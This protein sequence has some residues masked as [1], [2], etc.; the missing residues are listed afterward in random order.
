MIDNI[1]SINNNDFNQLTDAEAVAVFRK[2]LHAEAR[3]LGI[4]ITAIRITDRINVSDGGIDAI[5]DGAQIQIANDL[6]KNGI[7]SYQIKASTTFVPTQDAVIKEELFGDKPAKIENLKTQIK[8]CLNKDGTY[9]LVCFKQDLGE[10][11]HKR[12]ISFLDKYLKN[13]GYTNPKVEVWSQNNLKGLI[14]RFPGIVVE[15]KNLTQ[16]NFYSHQQWSEQREMSR[17]Y[18]AG[19]EQQDF[20][21]AIRSSLAQD[22]VPVQIHIVG[23]PGIGKTRL[24][25][26]ATQPDDVAPLVIYCENPET[27]NNNLKIAILRDDAVNAV[28]IIDECGSNNRS[29]I[30]NDLYNKSPRI[31]LMTIYNEYEQFRGNILEVPPLDPVDISTILQSYDVPENEAYYRW[32]SYCGGSPRVAHVIG[33]NLQTNPEDIL[34]SPDTVNIWDRYVAGEKSIDDPEIKKIKRVLQYISLF[35]RFGYGIPVT[36]EAQI[37]SGIIE[38]RSRGQIT[39]DDFNEIVKKLMARKIL[40]GKTTLYITPKALHIKLW[41]EWWDTYSNGFILEDFYQEIR[42]RQIITWFNEMFVYAYESKM[43]QRVVKDLLGPTGPFKDS[44]LIQTKMGADFF[45]FLAEADPA[46][47]LTCLKRIFKN[48][49]REEF[50]NFRTGRREVIWALEKMVVWEDLFVEAAKLLLLLAESE[51]ETWSNNASGVFASLFSLGYG[52]RI[53]PTKAPPN[54]RYQ[55]LEE[56][57]LSNSKEKRKLA[58]DA[59]NQALETQH[60]HRSIDSDYHGLRPAPDTWEPKTYGELFDAYRQIWELL[61]NNLD[62]L[63]EQEQKS[64]ISILLDRVPQLGSIHNLSNMVLETLKNLT[65]KTYVDKDSVLAA[66]SRIL[67]FEGANLPEDLRKGWESFKVEL[68]KTDFSS[69]LKRYTG[70]I[71]IEDHYDANRNYTDQSD[72]I[73]Q[74]LAEKVLENPK[75]LNPELGWLVTSNQYKTT[76]FGNTLGKFDVNNIFLSPIIEAIDKENQFGELYFLG[77]YFRALFERDYRNWELTLEKL[78]ENSERNYIL[79]Q[80]VARSGLSEKL[81]IKILE[82]AKKGV[83]NPSEF[84]SL[85]FSKIENISNK[86]FNSIVTFLLTKKDTASIYTALILFDFYYNNREKKQKL[87]KGKALKLLAH[88]TLHDKKTQQISED[89]FWTKLANTLFESYPETGV[90]ICELIFRNFG[91]RD[92]IINLYTG[93]IQDLLNRIA[94]RFPEEIWELT[95]NYLLDPGSVKSYDI[96]EWLRGRRFFLSER[97]VPGATLLPIQKIWE[98]IDKDVENRAW[99][100]ATFVPKDLTVDKKKLSIAR[101]LLKKYGERDDVQRNLWAN[102]NTEGI[103]GPRSVHYRLKRDELEKILKEENDKNVKAWLRA[104]I[105]E[106]NERI[107]IADI[108]EERDSY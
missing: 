107:R 35:K 71:F 90:D 100:V 86:T 50:L 75:L 2:L 80:I 97:D 22:D 70:S 45:R 52:G 9:V 89:Y 82:L 47:A 5:V 60:F 37:I 79:A 12:A 3:R 68:T 15:I 67:F 20:I 33:S 77:G 29:R 48:W 26:E 76:Y 1:F 18:N 83:I 88:P 31:K 23:E 4:P 98:W 8:N 81:L 17:N 87:P 62:N 96:K 105:S 30:W 53:A 24:V 25:L 85:R 28:V 46:E 14:N 91:Q 99:L 63:S 108:E 36:N 32:A 102:Y 41:S 106:L 11:E 43:A 103:Q 40:Q 10:R 55:V 34:L 42:D 64:A 73:F 49:S 6:V 39:W 72:L 7:T 16:L 27:F 65:L 93:Q 78:S 58:L 54:E 61:V 19:K 13:C 104:Y 38:N 44:D 95:S 92:S 56:A 21:S 57:L 69:L 51:N 74:Q 66:V 94:A 59:I 101:E 84:Y